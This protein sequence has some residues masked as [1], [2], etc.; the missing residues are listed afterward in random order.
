MRI[1]VDA[2]S[3]CGGYRG[4]YRFLTNIL[5]ELQRIDQSNEYYLYTKE[6][7]ALPFSNPRWRKRILAQ[8]PS[9]FSSR[10]AQLGLKNMIKGDDLDV[11]WETFH[12]FPFGLPRF[13]PRVLTIYDLVWRRHSETMQ[14]RNY[15]MHRLLT[16][17]SIRRTDHIIT[18]SQ[19]TAGELHALGMPSDKISIAYPAPEKGY[20]PLEHT[21]AAR[22]IANKYGASESYICAVGA[23]EPRKNLPTLLEATSILLHKH[24]WCCQL[25]V[26][27]A[28]SWKH[29]AIYESARNL[30]LTDNDVR[31]LGYV[32][33][34]DL[35]ALYCGSRLFVFPSLYEGF[36]IPLI[37]AMACGVPLV[38]SNASSMPEV[39]QDAG[40]LVSPRSPEG[41]AD[42]IRRVSSDSELRAS[43]IARGLRRAAD[44]SWEVSARK[45]H[46]LLTRCALTRER[47]NRQHRPQAAS[48]GEFEFA[49]NGA[50]Q[51]ISTG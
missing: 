48:R 3:L 13:L 8:E 35:P 29:S 44:F 11:F 50:S 22:Y 14:F 26:A 17:R 5:R 10:W 41:F 37:E 34:E 12:F 51:K 33:D 45:I 49:S 46:D 20:G 15:W 42:A 6:D 43:M 2:R 36:G 7:F 39:V 32:P 4:I 24:E 38:A 25:V 28:A 21:E 47:V 23:V 27:G 30:G 1:G 18:I 40:V 9:R 19:F 31:F 16:P